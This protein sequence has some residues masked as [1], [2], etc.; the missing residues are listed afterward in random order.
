[1]NATLKPSKERGNR[2]LSTVY[3]FT[4]PTP[5]DERVAQDEI[6]SITAANIIMGQ[7]PEQQC[8]MRSILLYQHSRIGCY[9]LFASLE[10][11][12]F[13]SRCLNGQTIG[14]NT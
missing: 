13:G 6:S 1:M 12:F 4:R 9:T 2:A 8:L 10:T 11:K 3:S 7:V 5:L 14:V